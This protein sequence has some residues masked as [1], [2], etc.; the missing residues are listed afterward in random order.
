MINGKEKTVLSGVDTSTINLD[1]LFF[2]GSI[3]NLYSTAEAPLTQPYNQHA[4]VYSGIKII[5]Q[6]LACVP[7]K[8]WKDPEFKNSNLRK[9]F[10]KEVYRI[11]ERKNNRSIKTKFALEHRTGEIRNQIYKASVNG[12]F[13]TV[14]KLTGFEEVKSHEIIDLFDRPNPH[15][16]GFELWEATI[17]WL[18][19]QGSCFWILS[20]SNYKEYPKEIWPTGPKGWKPIV[21]E[22]KKVITG[23]E[24]T[25]TVAGADKGTPK[26]IKLKPYE[27]VWFKQFDPNN[28]LRG[29]SSVRPA[30][31]SVEQDYEA[32]VYNRQFFKNGAQA[33]VILETEEVLKDDHK[34]SLLKSW[35]ARHKGSRKAHKTALLDGGVQARVLRES[36]RDMEFRLLRE[37]S[38]DEILSAL[39]VPKAMAGVIEDVNRATFLGS[40][41]TFF[42]TTLIPVMEYITSVLYAELFAPIEPELY[43]FFDLALVEG[44]RGD[45]KEK[46]EVSSIY[47]N[48][49]V[50][51]NSLND[52]FDLGFAHME[53]G[54]E[55]FLHGE[56]VDQILAQ[57]SK[58][59]EDVTPDTLPDTTDDEISSPDDESLYDDE[60][61]FSEDLPEFTSLLRVNEII[62]AKDLVNLVN[63]GGKICTTTDKLIDNI[64]HMLGTGAQLVTINE[65][66]DAR[67]KKFLS[68]I[69]GL[70]PCFNYEKRNILIKIAA[71]A[72]KNTIYCINSLKFYDI[73]AKNSK[74]TWVLS[75]KCR[76]HRSFSKKSVSF[77]QDGTLYPIGNCLC[78]LISEED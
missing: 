76:K 54:D 58:P 48:L 28:V 55:P 31:L 9:D 56:P 22:K 10:T 65:F 59:S 42:E 35:E 61:V 19:A 5:A 43:G 67:T 71:F 17:T 52:R 23:W 60:K 57:G 39:G 29:L 74:K 51:F 12:D 11:E 41:R 50:P 2:S 78:T 30:L 66:I 16:V 25:F 62:Y 7:F 44:L 18:K 1:P 32:Q 63:N 34:Q 15:M 14:Q 64:T 47:H 75:K 49:G 24:Y 8:V 37:L 77:A 13:D 53:H 27:V 69:K 73:D 68:E 4:Y 33:D 26:T 21:S 72:R 40:K 20:R 3:H 36:H 38:R 45:V 46:A 6:N 70:N